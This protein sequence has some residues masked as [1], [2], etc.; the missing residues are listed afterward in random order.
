MNLKKADILKLITCMIIKVVHNS[1]TFL[2]VYQ[3]K[4]PFMKISLGKASVSKRIELMRYSLLDCRRRIDLF[5]LLL[6][7]RRV[8]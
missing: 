2:I 7:R 5:L 4:R 6:I 8:A 3:Y 1:D